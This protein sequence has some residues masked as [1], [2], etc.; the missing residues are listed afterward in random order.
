MRRALCLLSLAGAL[1]AA[2]CP[3]PADAPRDPDALALLGTVPVS[4]LPK[5]SFTLT[6]TRGRPYDFRAETDGH[7]TLLFFGYTFCPDICPVHMATLSAA[8]REL[9]PAVRQD[10]R[11]VFVTVDPQRD[12]PERLATWL[13]AF[14]SSFVGVRGS[15]ED[16]AAALAFY[17]YPP[18]DRSGDE[19]GYTVGHPALI[20][21]FTPDDLGRAMYGPDTRKNTW[22]HDL[23]VMAGHDWSRA[24]AGARPA[25]VGEGPAQGSGVQ[26]LDAVIPRPPTA[27]STALYATLSNPGTQTDTLLEISTAVAQRASLHEMV[28]EGGVMH[29]TPLPHGL[30]LPAGA[31][32]RLE[33]GAFHGMLE[34]LTGPLEVGGTV[35]VTFRFARAGDL[36]VPVRVVRYEDVGR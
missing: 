1:T 15:E 28:A 8:L 18:P 4:P 14:D 31:T 22:I 36:E 24:R 11:V 25:A 9:D 5:V 33:P 2:A 30:P 26:V 35:L 6:D 17:R 12:T 19:T 7:I 20:Y 29:M 27:T 16:V 10:V 21:A 34:G 32:V 3:A 13:A 23:E